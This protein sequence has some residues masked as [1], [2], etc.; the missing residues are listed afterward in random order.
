MNSRCKTHDLVTKPG[1]SNNVGCWLPPRTTKQHLLGKALDEVVIQITNQ[2]RQSNISSLKLVKMVD[3]YLKMT[4]CFSQLLKTHKKLFVRVTRWYKY[5]PQQENIMVDFFPLISPVATNST[6]AS[7]A[8]Q[9]SSSFTCSSE[10]TN[11]KSKEDPH[12]AVKI[13]SQI[14]AHQRLIVYPEFTIYKGFFW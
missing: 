3:S 6:V 14:L 9:L 10:V 1:R 12:E 7:L 11:K 4:C 8:L 5:P 2:V 13:S